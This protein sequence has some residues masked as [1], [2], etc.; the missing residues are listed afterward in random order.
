M[1]QLSVSGFGAWARFSVLC[2]DACAAPAHI[3]SKTYQIPYLH[4]AI[5]S[6]LRGHWRTS[7][8]WPGVDGY[9]SSLKSADV[10]SH[11]DL[12]QAGMCSSTSIRVKL[13]AGSGGAGPTLDR[14]DMGKGNRRGKKETEKQVLLTSIHRLN[15]FHPNCKTTSDSKLQVLLRASSKEC[16]SA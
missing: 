7:M 4:E 9:D 8:P 6:T 1:L 13:P 12:T 3:P 11:R 10:W 15:L 5:R 2:G 14:G 16:T